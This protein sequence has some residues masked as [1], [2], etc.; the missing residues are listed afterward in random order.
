MAA[1][2]F[3]QS[4]QRKVVEVIIRSRQL[5]SGLHRAAIPA[6]RVVTAVKTLRRT[7]LAATTV[8]T[9][10]VNGGSEVIGGA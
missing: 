6:M 1:W 10:V 4:S 2:T 8:G 7:V 5:Y 3:A 9:G